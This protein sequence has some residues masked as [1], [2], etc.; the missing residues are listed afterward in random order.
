MPRNALRN[1]HVKIWARAEGPTEERRRQATEGGR[2]PEEEST[3][4]E[5]TVLGEP[6]AKLSLE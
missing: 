6:Q 2:K 5:E 3:G 4:A 1:A